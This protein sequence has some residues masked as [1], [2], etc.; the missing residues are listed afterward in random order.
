MLRKLSDGLL[1]GFMVSFGSAIFLA[2]DVKYVGAFLFCIALVVICN[3]G[4]NLF[5][6]KVGYMVENHKKE[7]FSV[8]LIGLFGN[9]VVTCL[10]G[11]AIAYAVPEIGE[12]ALVLCTAK[13]EQEFFQTL[14]RAIFCGILMYLAVCLVQEHHTPLGIFFCIPV[15]SLSGDEHSIAN[16]F[17]FGASG[18]V[19]LEAFKFI[20]VAI[21]GNSIGG[22][23]FPVLK[24]P[25]KL[26]NK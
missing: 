22:M 7:D 23:L 19:S 4:Y 13:L 6:G 15:F 8:L 12:K 9:A 24:L 17:Y 16:M 3:E 20:C 14:I 21:L 18:I 2:C 1:A 25:R 5:T 11:M 26:G 10:A